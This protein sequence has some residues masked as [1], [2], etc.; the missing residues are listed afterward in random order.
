M[1]VEFTVFEVALIDVSSGTDH[2]SST[3]GLVVDP[4]SLIEGVVFPDLLSFAVTHSIAK[5]ANVPHSLLHADG[6]LGDERRQL[7]IAI[8]EWSDSL[9]DLPGNTVVEVGRLKVGLT[10]VIDNHGVLVLRLDVFAGIALTTHIL[11]D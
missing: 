6:P 8:F 9:G 3:V 11:L 5:L 4:E 7:V 2:S 1:A 10:N